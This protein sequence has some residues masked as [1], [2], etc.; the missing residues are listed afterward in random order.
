MFCASLTISVISVG[1]AGV[2]TI[3]GWIMTH[4]S[5]LRSQRITPKGREGRAFLLHTWTDLEACRGIG[6]IDNAEYAT[7]FER[8]I[9][10]VPP[11]E[12]A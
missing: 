10:A 5:T 3:A 9:A 6:D 1:I 7:V 4:F 12:G 11:S 2:I 8:A